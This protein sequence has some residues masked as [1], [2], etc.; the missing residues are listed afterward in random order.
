MA[1]KKKRTYKR[2]T[3]DM[4][5]A[6]VLQIRRGVPLHKVAQDMGCHKGT[7]SGR[8]RA[9]RNLTVRKILES[10]PGEGERRLYPRN[11]GRRMADIVREVEQHKRAIELLRK[12]AKHLTERI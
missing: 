8:L 9:D 7:L 2:V 5:D 12:E 6:A 4:L 1:K 11:I 10:K 3:S